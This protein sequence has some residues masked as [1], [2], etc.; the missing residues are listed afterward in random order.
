[1]RDNGQRAAQRGGDP[2]QRIKLRG[3]LFC[4]EAGYDRL[5]EARGVCQ[6]LL[7]HLTVTALFDEAVDDGTTGVRHGPHPLAHN[8]AHTDI[9]GRCRF[10]RLPR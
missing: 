9:P 8:R 3:R 7:G 4:F 5:G 1:M 2:E 6:L 10:R